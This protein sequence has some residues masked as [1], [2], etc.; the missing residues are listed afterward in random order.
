MG[1]YQPAPPNAEQRQAWDGP[2]GAFWAANA[3]RYDRAV[4]AYD[5]PL[6]DAAAI[7]IT[8]RV[9]DIGCGNGRTTID[10]AR[11]APKGSALGIDLSSAMLDVAR[12]RASAEGVGNASFVLGDAQVHPF[13]PASFDVALSRTGTMFFGDH[14]AAFANIAAAVR[15]GGRLALLVWQPSAEN[16]WFGT[17][18]AALSAGRDLPAPPSGPPPF[19][20]SDPDHVR[21]L[22]G[23]TGFGEIEVTSQRAG[24]WFGADAGDA[25]QFVLGQLGW[26]LEGLDD[27]GRAQATEN[28]LA[29]MAAHETGDGVVF[30]SATWLVTARRGG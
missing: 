17:F 21:S 23:D 14:R 1:E 11:C 27:D 6:L 26:M 2:E 4:A 28:L 22:L 3:D 13:E 15:H 25:H 10:A 12:R 7:E 18:V 9:L 30:G 29:A 8:D 24:M 20:Q 16:E 19:S 5:R